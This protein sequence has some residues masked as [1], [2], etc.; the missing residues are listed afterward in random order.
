MNIIPQFRVIVVE[1]QLIA[2]L[3]V[4]YRDIDKFRGSAIMFL[5]DRGIQKKLVYIEYKA[6]SCLPSR[7]E[8]R[9]CDPS[10]SAVG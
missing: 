5:L 9:R 10:L 2:S 3:R 8:V 1:T 6:I 7:L 4:E